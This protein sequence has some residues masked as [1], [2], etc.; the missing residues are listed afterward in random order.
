MEYN[1]FERFCARHERWGVRNLMLYV[2]IANVA[3]F[4]LGSTQYGSKFIVDWLLFMPS[5]IAKG[6]I[7]RVITFVLIPNVGDIFSLALSSM[8]YFFVGR[9]LES[10]WG[11][12]KFTIYYLAGV[13]L[14]A[15]FA[16]IMSIWYGDLV[17]M[18]TLSGAHYLNM[19]LF[20]AYAIINPDG[21]V[22]MYLII[23]IKMKWLA[24]ID[25]AYILVGV[26]LNPFPTNMFPLVALLNCA[27]FFAP[28]AFGLLRRKKFETSN[29]ID[30]QK[31]AREHE[32]AVKK[33][34]YTH[35]CVVCG[36]TDVTHPDEEFRYCSQCKGYACYCSEHI[37]NHTHI[38]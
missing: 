8:F 38:K 29:R 7:W 33:R 23:P 32:K 21:M 28:R 34:G 36:K 19:S 14:Q 22:R 26:V 24:L 31:K 4:I 9:V 17:A 2:I 15:A 27:L 3:L 30:F 25:L 13:L 35:R 12:L 16:G 5:K 1:R 37:L 11:R 6:Q 18:F 20:L 10:Q